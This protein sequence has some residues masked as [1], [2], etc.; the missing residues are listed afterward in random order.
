MKIF[1]VIFHGVL[2][3]GYGFLFIRQGNAEPS[4]LNIQE[5]LIYLVAVILNAM[6]FSLWITRLWITCTPRD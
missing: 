1:W 4:M 3:F 5:M 6:C 2:V